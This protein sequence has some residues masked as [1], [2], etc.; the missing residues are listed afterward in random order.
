MLA[1]KDRFEGESYHHYLKLENV[2]LTAI[3]GE[4]PYKE[5]VDLIRT[6]YSDDLNVDGLIQEL[7]VL[8]VLFADEHIVCFDDILKKFISCTSDPDVL[9]NVSRLLILILVLPATSASAERSFSL[10][11]RLK[12]WLRSRMEQKRFNSL[13]IL[14]EFK[15]R[16]DNIDLI[17][18]GNEFVK[19]YDNRRLKFGTF[20]H[21]DMNY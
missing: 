5:G 14:Y 6:E 21:S 18:I 8:K 15:E 16:T 11:R 20:E 12:I 19:K 17:E 10:Q 3:D 2:L 1:L 13:A 4:E 7:S 9:P